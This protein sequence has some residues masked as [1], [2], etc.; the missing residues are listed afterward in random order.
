MNHVSSPIAT[1]DPVN[2]LYIV[3]FNKLARNVEERCRMTCET[4]SVAEIETQLI[5]RASLLKIASV[6][7]DLCAIRNVISWVVKHQF[8]PE[9]IDDKSWIIEASMEEIGQLHSGLLRTGRGF[10]SLGKE[11]SSKY[12]R[13]VMEMNYPG[14]EE[15]AIRE[16]TGIRTRHSYHPP[17]DRKGM[18]L[19]TD[20]DF[21]ELELHFW[22]HAHLN[23]IKSLALVKADGKALLRI[24]MRTIRLTGMRPIEVFTC[25]IYVGDVTREYNNEDIRKIQD[26]PYQAVEENMLVPFDFDPLAHRSLGT[27]VQSTIETTGISPILRIKAAKTTNANPEL[28]LPFRVQVLHKIDKDDL[29]VLC[30]AAYL[31]H[32]PLK[33]KRQTNLITSMSRN[34]RA[35]ADVTLPHRTDKLNLYSFR[36]DFAT[37]AKLRMPVWEVAALLGHT[38]RASTRA[39]GKLFTRQ[40]KGSDSGWMPLRDPE[41]AENIRLNWGGVSRQTPGIE[42]DGSMV[43]VMDTGDNM[44]EIIDTDG[45]TGEAINTDTHSE[46]GETGPEPETGHE[47][48]SGHEPATDHDMETDSEPLGTEIHEEHD[49][50]DKP[51]FEPDIESSQP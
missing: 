37:R 48:E 7:R 10:E 39:Y 2:S 35:A 40:R 30:L 22:D 34:L 6:H 51:D 47:Q 8:W 1:P 21:R 9:G 5:L 43:D 32:F 19:I 24:F 16:L 3:D 41:F 27:M 25:R 12:I 11:V 33:T 45:G 49:R 23:A 13:R 28:V 36:H 42:S 17:R 44:G 15:D 38:S 31:H 20:R 14:S 29:E 18:A 26:T 46:H 50:H 4:P